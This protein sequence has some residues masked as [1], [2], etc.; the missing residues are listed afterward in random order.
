M[1]KALA[2]VQFT[3]CEIPYR[4]NEKYWLLQPDKGEV[5][6]I[7]SVNYEDKTEQAL[8]RVMMIEYTASEKK[9]QRSANIAY[10]E[11][12]PQELV[13]KF[14]SAA[15]EKPTNGFLVISKYKHSA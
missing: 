3:P 5:Q 7:F 12:V 2:G 13:A 14:P 8:A 10:K 9:I 15:Q 6:I 1:K 4:K 11:T